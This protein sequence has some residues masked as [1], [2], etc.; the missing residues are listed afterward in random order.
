MKSKRILFVF[1]TPLYLL[2]L[3]LAVTC[4]AS[5]IDLYMA[6]GQGVEANLLIMFDNSGS[7]NDE[8]Q[9]Y[10]YEPS[11]TYDPLVVS[12]ANRDTVYYRVYGGGWNLFANSIA[13]V[14]CSSARTALTNH[15]HY[16]GNTNSSCS[17]TTRT[18]RTGNYRNYLASVGGSEFLPKLTIA[19][20]VMEDFLNTI[21]GVRIGMM[22]FNNSEGGRIHSTIRSLDETTRS[23]LIHEEKR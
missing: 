13:D 15:G 10:F 4:F 22:V 20:R 19:K 17:R 18:L 1:F 14:A 21:H 2:Y 12:Q 11:T 16:E 3:L 9:A 8:I 5:D 7:M 6:S 23:Q